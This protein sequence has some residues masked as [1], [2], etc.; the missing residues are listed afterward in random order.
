MSRKTIVL[1]I[2]DDSDIREMVKSRLKASGYAVIEASGGL[3]GLEKANKEHPDLIL[4]NVMMPDLSGV[5]T[6]IR[7][8]QSE[9]TEFIPII[10]VT[11]I[12]ED[13]ARTLVLRIGGGDYIIKPFEGQE[14]VDKIEK[15][16]KGP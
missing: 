4:L 12:N 6:A 1:V 15:I 7:L 11:G 16:L 8:K 2:D 13:E 10:L 14:L 9:E 5:T 3:E